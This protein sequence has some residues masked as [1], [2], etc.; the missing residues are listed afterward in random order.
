[1]LPC[2]AVL[3]KS[4]MDPLFPVIPSQ[5]DVLFTV[6]PS[7]INAFSIVLLDF[8]TVYLKRFFS[9]SFLIDSFKNKLKTL[10]IPEASSTRR[11]GCHPSQKPGNREAR[12]AIYATA[13]VPIFD[14]VF[15][16]L[17]RA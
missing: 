11:S 7:Q 4:F 13:A 17:T 16:A 10:T 2:E 5:I 8:T 15:F 9:M 6:I 3:W 1:M 12:S 14:H